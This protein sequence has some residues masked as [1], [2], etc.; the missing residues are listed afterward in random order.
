MR[1]GS[2]HL[3]PPNKY[4]P[5]ATRWHEFRL[6]GIGGMCVPNMG[7]IG[8]VSNEIEGRVSGHGGK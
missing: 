4:I 1:G 8:H 5:D 3:P 7:S 2:T 6:G